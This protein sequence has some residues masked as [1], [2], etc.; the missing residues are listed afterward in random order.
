[1]KVKNF[2]TTKMP[3]FYLKKIE[4][5]AQITYVQKFL[6]ISIK[7]RS[8]SKIFFSVANASRKGLKKQ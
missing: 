1:M 7:E 6:K 8:L 3:G 5:K 2:L 4:T